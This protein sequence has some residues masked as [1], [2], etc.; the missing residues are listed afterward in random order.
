VPGIV[1]FRDR[2]ILRHSEAG[3]ACGDGVEAS[4]RIRDPLQ[5]LVETGH[6]TS[7]ASHVVDG[8]AAEARIGDPTIP[9]RIAAVI[10][11]VTMVFSLTSNPR[12]SR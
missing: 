11:K 3:W 1:V 10:L 6:R 8:S 12:F 9:N 5:V 7:N 2:E 4:G